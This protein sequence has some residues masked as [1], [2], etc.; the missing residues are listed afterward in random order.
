[1]RRCHLH[2]KPSFPQH[3]PAREPGA[4]GASSSGGFRQRGRW[5]C[6]PKDYP[7]LFS[8]LGMVQDLCDKKEELNLQNVCMKEGCPENK[9]CIAC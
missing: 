2:Q 9:T 5:D 7:T 3:R 1:M 8:S 6:Q 4:G